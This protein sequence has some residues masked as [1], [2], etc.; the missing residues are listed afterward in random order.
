LAIL[1]AAAVALAFSPIMAQDAHAATLNEQ[2]PNNDPSGY[3][4]FS[5]NKSYAQAVAFGNTYNCSFID[6]G[7]YDWYK[8][9]LP[10]AT[11]VTMVLKKTAMSGPTGTQ[12]FATFTLYQ[13]EGSTN[14]LSRDSAYFQAN[15]STVN[16]VTELP[17]GTFYLQVRPGTYVA[18]GSKNK[19][20]ISFVNKG[21]LTRASAP[22]DFTMREKSGLTYVKKY[23]SVYSDSQISASDYDI[24]MTNATKA[25]PSVVTITGKGKY[26]GTLTYS[27]NKFLARTYH[28]ATAN[29]KKKTITINI[30]KYSKVY[31]ATGYIIKYK[32]PGK[33]WKTKKVTKT[34]Y[35]FKK[36]KNLKKGKKFS[37]Q[38]IAYAKVGKSTYY[39]RSS[40]SPAKVWDKATYKVY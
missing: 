30:A 5:Y 33:G 28:G 12:G 34:K 1:V 7:D 8:F 14:G 36:V 4:S 20:S 39:S 2:E 40:L 15:V 22:T 31:G 27:V 32:F 35:T 11:P 19:Y 10:S 25:G 3:G 6:S 37:F 9:T 26:Y 29:F 17:A 24:A 18:A 13:D 16:F 23:L 21:L 38:V